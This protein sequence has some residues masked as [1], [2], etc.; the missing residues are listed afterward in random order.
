MT[1]SV[2]CV[3]M[4]KDEEDVAEHV[5]MHMVD[6]GV[7]GIIVADNMSTDGTRAK[8]LQAAE[9]AES[10]GV[11]LVLEI[12]D[13]PGYYQS[14]KMTELARKAADEYGAEWIVPF[15]ADE[16]WYGNDRVGVVLSS[17]PKAVDV[18]A[19]SITN[20]FATGVDPE[21]TN[22]FQTME[23]RQAEPQALP[24]VAFRWSPDAKIEQGN[25]AVTLPSSFPYAPVPA[26]K[27]RHFPY[28][29]FEHFVKKAKN[30]AEAY[31]AAVDLPEDM[32]KHWRQYGEL[33]ERH[34]E[35][36]LREVYTTWFWF[37]APV[38]AGM[39]HDPAPF[40]RW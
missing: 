10:K 8:I 24:K 21:G 13:E 39:V 1:E 38:N 19:C 29:S 12:D 2:W 20:H 5:L 9:Y 14:Q 23:W 7:T 27:L 6:E 16:L 26:L 36:A 37:L 34:G 40:R 4:F 32:G 33:L 18:V 25:H 22:P 30:G 15:D 11:H 28:R 17:L 3:S 35:E 31:K